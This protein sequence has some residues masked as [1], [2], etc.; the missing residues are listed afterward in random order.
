FSFWWSSQADELHPLLVL[1]LVVTALPEGEGALPRH[2]AVLAGLDGGVEDLMGRRL[3]PRFVERHEE[4]VGVLVLK[5]QGEA[6][7][8]IGNVRRFGLRGRHGGVAR[9][10]GDQLVELAMAAAVLRR[11]LELN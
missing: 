4:V 8:T 11:D 9:D 3:A 5:T 1:V 2:E 7:T 6:E 10:H